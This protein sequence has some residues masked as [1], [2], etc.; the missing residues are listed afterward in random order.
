MKYQDIISG[1]SK[2]VV[3]TKSARPV[4]KPGTKKVATPDAKIRSRQ[5]AKLKDSGDMK[6]A[7]DLILNN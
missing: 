2:A 6:D 4:L 3:K 1:K 5:Q 7:L